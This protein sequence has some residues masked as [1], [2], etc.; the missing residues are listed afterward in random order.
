MEC[1]SSEDR[2]FEMKRRNDTKAVSLLF[3]REKEPWKRHKHIFKG[4]VI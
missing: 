1:F 3:L 4:G 2:S